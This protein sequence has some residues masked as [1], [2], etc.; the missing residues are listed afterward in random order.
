[1]G[2]SLCRWVNGGLDYRWSTDLGGDEGPMKMWRCIQQNQ[3]KT[4]ENLGVH[5][6]LS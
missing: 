1:M 4:C 2:E 3:S 6:C 5:G